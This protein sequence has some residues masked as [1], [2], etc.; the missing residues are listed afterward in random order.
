[1]C[2]LWGQWCLWQLQIVCEVLALSAL[3][4]NSNAEAST[5]TS[6]IVSIASTFSPADNAHNTLISSWLPLLGCIISG[7]LAVSGSLAVLAVAI[8]ASQ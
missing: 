2:S 4:A 8:L 3:L 5:S 7:M 6:A 1:M